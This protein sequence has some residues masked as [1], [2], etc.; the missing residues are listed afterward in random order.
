MTHESKALRGNPPEV[1]LTN[2]HKLWTGSYVKCSVEIFEMILKFTSVYTMYLNFE[3]I[4]STVP[5]EIVV[6]VISGN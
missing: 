4:F 5:W 3:I 2:G 6:D 1:S